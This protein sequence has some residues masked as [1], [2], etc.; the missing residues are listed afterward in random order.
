M[1]DG[2]N[3][4]CETLDFDITIVRDPSFYPAALL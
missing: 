3:K 2:D 1:R 4:V